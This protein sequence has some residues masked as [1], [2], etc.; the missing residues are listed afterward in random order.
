M[1]IILFTGWLFPAGM[2]LVFIAQWIRNILVPTLK[3]GDF[4]QLYDLHGIRYLDSTLAFT[5]VAF[6]WLAVAV[7]RWARLQTSATDITH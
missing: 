6:F 3:G 7:F 4:N 5:T 1:Q 2:A